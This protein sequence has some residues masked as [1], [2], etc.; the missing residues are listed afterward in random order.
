MHIPTGFSIHSP[1]QGTIKRKMIECADQ[2]CL[3]MDSS[4]I[5]RTALT[6]FAGFSD[7]D[8]I[9]TE[10]AFSDEDSAF[11]SSQGIRVLLAQAE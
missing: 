2:V 4:K 5:N 6:I 7:I 3:L 9:V 11:L 8:I 10:K 1:F